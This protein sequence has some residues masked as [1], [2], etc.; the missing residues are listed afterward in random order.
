MIAELH[1]VFD[2]EDINSDS[3]HYN[4]GKKAG[5]QFE[6]KVLLSQLLLLIK[7]TVSIS[8]LA[9]NPKTNFYKQA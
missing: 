4:A 5:R 3:Q 8:S 2:A 1:K 7:T 9:M 6:E